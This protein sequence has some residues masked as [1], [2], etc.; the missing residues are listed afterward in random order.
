MVIEG[1]REGAPQRWAGW[2]GNTQSMSVPPPQCHP[3]TPSSH[4]CGRF[5][6]ARVMDSVSAAVLNPEASIP[7]PGHR[8]WVGVQRGA[9]PI[10]SF[11]SHGA[12]FSEALVGVLLESQ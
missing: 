7:S 9:V 11:H 2:P 6:K 4:V 8:E 5:H 1:L 12:I 3:N 10:Y